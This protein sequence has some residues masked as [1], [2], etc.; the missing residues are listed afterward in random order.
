MGGLEGVFSVVD[1]IVVAGCGQTME[2]AQ[3]DNQQKLNKT[4]KKCAEKQIVLNKDKQQT[5]LTEI[6]F[7]GHIIT[8]DGVK[9]D[10]A[11]VQAIRDMP[12][13]THAAGVKRPC[14]T[15]Q[16]MSRFLPDLAETIEPIRAL[17][18]KNTLFV[19]SMECGNAIDTLKRNLSESQC[20]AYFD[21]SKEIVIQ[22]DCSKHGI[23]DV[24]LQDGHPVEYASRA[25]TPSERNWAQIEKEAL[26]VLFGLG[27]FDQYTYGRPVKVKNDQKPLATILRKPLS[28]TP[29]CL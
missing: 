20:L 2:E 5:G 10:E 25:L 23:G 28:Q 14:G 26:S 9:A 17:T 7:H 22:V 4:L 27:R 29:K 21:V 15:V 3:I 11:K 8:K 12:A 1:D 16:D 19:W 6:T 13:P 24:L 18:R